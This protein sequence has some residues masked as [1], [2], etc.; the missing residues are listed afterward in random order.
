MVTIFI[1]IVRGYH[2][3]STVENSKLAD[4]DIKRHWDVSLIIYVRCVDYEHIYLHIKQYCIIEILTFFNYLNPIAS[5][6]KEYAT[7]EKIVLRPGQ[8]KLIPGGE[9]FS[10]YPAST[11]IKPIAIG[12]I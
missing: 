6:F 9:Y 1:E 3:I 11:F 10:Q 4:R 2:A 8:F 5:A 7:T 12:F